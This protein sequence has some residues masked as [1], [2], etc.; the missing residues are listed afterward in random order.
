MHCGSLRR[1]EE[2]DSFGPSAVTKSSAARPVPKVAPAKLMRV[3]SSIAK[4]YGEAC[5]I[6]GAL[7]Q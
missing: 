5:P 4:D 3:V 6:V 1:G 7:L 2:A